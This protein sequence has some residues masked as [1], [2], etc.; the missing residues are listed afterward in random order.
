MVAGPPLDPRDLELVRR[1]QELNREALL[2]Y[3]TGD[4]LTDEVIARLQPVEAG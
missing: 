4:L 1:W 3:W 2:A